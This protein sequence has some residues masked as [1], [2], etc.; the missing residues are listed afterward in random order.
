MNNLQKIELLSPAKDAA[1]GI[2]AIQCGADAV[3]IGGG[4]FSARQAAGNSIDDIKKLTDHA[5]LFYAKVYAAVNTLLRDDELAAAQELI[6]SLYEAGIDG[7]IIQD[8]GLLKMDLPPLPLIASTQMHNN[9]AD[10]VKFLE[11][12]GFSRVIL[13]RELTIEQIREIRKQTKIELE[14]FVHG[15]LCVGT[16]GQCYMSYAAGGRSGNRGQCAQ[17]CRKL[18]NLSDESGEAICENRYLLSLKDLNLSEYLEQ[19]I[20]AGITSFKIEGRLK[21][22]PYVVNITGHY[23]Q[24]I[25]MI[26]PSKGLKASSSG[27][28][29]LGF[30]PDPAKTFNRGYTDYGITG[31]TCDMG[32]ISTPKSVGEPIGRVSNTGLNYF[33]LEDDSIP[34]HNGDGICFFEDGGELGGTVV[35]RVEGARIYPQKMDMI[36]DGAV[37]FRNS[38][39]VFTKSL[40]TVPATRKIAIRLVLK[41]TPDGIELKIGDEDG[42][43]ATSAIKTNKDAAQ[44][45]ELARQNI[46]KQLSKFGDTIF[47]C[48]NV[49]VDMKQDYFFA[50]S[51]LNQLRRDAAAAMLETRVFNR[52]KPQRSQPPRKSAVYPQKE[53]DYTGNVLNEKAKEFYLEHGVEKITPAAESGLDM[54][55]CKVMTTKYCIRKQLGIC[56]GKDNTAPLFLS[57][58]N[59]NRFRLIFRCGDCGM[60][61]FKV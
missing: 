44:N 35:N 22:I 59:G 17:P 33:E 61:I 12:A 55:G 29:K 19:L 32:S 60:D 13:A 9:S 20:D 6:Y 24:M 31:K 18:Y 42:N 2:A 1:T 46:T 26:L 5:H 3:Y 50:A 10:K 30:T 52:P 49:A 25:D 57:D 28:V 23:R 16:S 53:L 37:I 48:E 15:A 21:N 56:A 38:D 8:T 14:C 54:K 11:D 40:E 36:G 27:K 41:E 34:L 47:E 4:Q 7:V 43:E 51:V 39:H 45:P 58:G